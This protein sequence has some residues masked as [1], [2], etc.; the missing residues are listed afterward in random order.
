MST[1]SGA[2]AP[3]SA[4]GTAPPA[5]LSCGAE[6]AEPST[7]LLCGTE[8]AEPPM[9]LLY[10]TEGAEP[11]MVFFCGT[12]GAE[13]ST[14]LLYGTEGAKPSMVPSKV[15]SYVAR[16]PARMLTST[17]S[18]ASEVLPP[19]RENTAEITDVDGGVGGGAGVDGGVD[20]GAGA[21]VGAGVVALHRMRVERRTPIL[22]LPALAARLPSDEIRSGSA[23][24]GVYAA[25]NERT[26]RPPPRRRYLRSAMRDVDRPTV[27]ACA[28]HCMPPSS[29]ATNAR[30]CAGGPIRHHPRDPAAA[31]GTRHAPT[32]PW[33]RIEIRRKGSRLRHLDR[34][35]DVPPQPD[36]TT[37][38]SFMVIP[39]SCPAISIVIL[40]CVTS[41]SWT[42]FRHL[43]DEHTEPLDIRV[44]ERCI[45][46]VE[47][48]ER[49][50]IQLED[51]EY[52][53]NRSERLLARPIADGCLCC[54]CPAGG[55]S[56]SRR[57][58]GHP[59][60]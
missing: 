59:R 47:E 44:I 2:V 5:V 49:R 3:G 19:W 41:T 35:L 58:R 48:A 45:D 52:Q 26:R 40:L 42:R 22:G 16:R 28:F 43:L 53:R 11:P 1:A 13:P 10:G 9:V 55:P 33:P 57:P 39:M 25:K 60:W 38:G 30:S 6:G 31:R 4:G 56:P 32:R 18:S 20:G 21:G 51:R 34:L 27:T 12:E 14:V 54:A 29:R 7:V 17:E 15:L 36:A 50:R 37:P 23:L 46:L 24:R 8:G